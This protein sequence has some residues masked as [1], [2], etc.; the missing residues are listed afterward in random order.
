MAVMAELN[1]VPDQKLIQLLSYIEKDSLHEPFFSEIVHLAINMSRTTSVVICFFGTPELSVV[2]AAG[3][4]LSEE[5]AQLWQSLV[6][7]ENYI[8]IEDTLKHALYKFNPQ[9]LDQ[10]VMRFLAGMPVINGEGAVIGVIGLTDTK[11]RKFSGEQIQSLGILSRLITIH[12]ETKKKLLV[13]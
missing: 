13:L 11:P 4:I 3:N 6:R 8:E 12:L 9:V 7:N 2:A 5:R 1:E 10:P